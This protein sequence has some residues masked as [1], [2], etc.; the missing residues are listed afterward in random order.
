MLSPRF[1]ESRTENLSFSNF[2][3]KTVHKTENPKAFLK[4]T[5]KS[6]GKKK[7]VQK[8]RKLSVVDENN[9]IEKIISSAAENTKSKLKK[10]LI[11]IF[12]EKNKL[13]FKKKKN[14]W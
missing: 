1:D 7:N 8:C 10:G 3:D 4:T 12:E 5:H 2:Y 13:D 11:S 14:I 6:K 9:Y